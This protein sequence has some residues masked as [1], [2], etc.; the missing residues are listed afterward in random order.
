MNQPITFITGNLGKLAWTQRFVKLPLEHKKLDLVEIQ[1]L[2]AKEV[3]E[4]K[5]KQAYELLKKPVL[6]E[7]T[8]LVFHAL[9][10]LPGTY[11]KW[12][13][14]ELTNEGLC[15]LIDNKD[16]SAT[17]TVLYGYY[18]GTNM[19]FGE[20]NVKGAIAQSP[21]GENGFGW[22]P[23]FIPEGYQQTHA[24]LNDEEFNKISVRKAAIED[25]QK[26]LQ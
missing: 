13:L 23:V 11:I 26:K 21:R 19:I 24:E 6:V 5:V 2:D 10:R 25:L 3:V 12:F 4:H 22:D 8:S 15:R 9:G 7:D 18:D 17:A 16:R 14:E 1:S 20:G